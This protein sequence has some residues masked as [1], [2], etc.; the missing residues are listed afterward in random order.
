MTIDNRRKC[1]LVIEMINE[2]R[3]EGI[4]ITLLHGTRG[5]EI[6]IVDNNASSP[7]DYVIATL[8]TSL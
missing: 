6:V 3:S 1:D 4:E 5:Y 2:L 8:E 7:G